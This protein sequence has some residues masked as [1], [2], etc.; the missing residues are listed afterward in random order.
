MAQQMDET[1]DRVPSPGSDDQPAPISVVVVEDSPHDAR[2]LIRALEKTG[3]AVTWEQT[4]DAKGLRAL[5]RAR[6]WDMVFSDHNMPE[7]SGQEALEIVRA[8][9]PHLPFVLVSGAIGEACAVALIKAGASDYLSKEH[10]SLAGHVVA[11]VLNEAA[12]RRA[13][14]QAEE[15]YRAMVESSPDGILL[16]DEEGLIERAN[17]QIGALLGMDDPA[18]LVGM[19][20]L[21]L[22]APE[23]Q[24]RAEELLRAVIQ[25][26]I[27]RHEAFTITRADQAQVHVEVRGVRVQAAQDERPALLVTVRD[28]TAHR[29][30][31]ATFRHAQKMEAI[32]R[33]AGGVAHDFNNIVNV[34][35]AFADFLREDLPA[36]D[37][38][39]GHVSEILAASERASNL[40]RQLLTFSRRSA[41]QP[42]VLDVTRTLTNMQAMLH[43]ILG[44]DVRVTI[45]LAERVWPVHIDEGHLEQVITNLAVNARDALPTG[46]EFRLEVLNRSLR[47]G[48]A[49]L[50]AGLEPGDHVLIRASDSGAGIP[51]E[52]HESI[53]DPFFTTKGSGRGTGLGLS[54]VYAILQQAK[55]RIQV[56]SP[57]GSGAVFSIWLPRSVASPQVEVASA[58]PPPGG[59]VFTGRRVLLVE[60]EV[61][62]RRAT[63]RTLERLGFEVLEASDGR[64][65]L[66]LMRRRGG[67]VDLVL[68]DVVMP[69]MSGREL[70][71]HLTTEGL[72]ERFVYMSGYPHDVIA[73]H[74]VLDADVILVQKPFTSTSLTEKLSLAFNAR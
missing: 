60:D 38:R 42:R 35:L 5:L 57:P 15:L 44:E 47:P 33:L 65:A 21:T 28:V 23:D 72:A 54:T 26:H 55:G 46:G 29:Q 51:A 66:A 63:C 49:E 27:D 20:A 58:R 59:T 32:G 39:Q 11:R 69:N 62:L 8:H 64:E 71:E 43:R 24:A 22:I 40:T 52:I 18:H 6:A 53:F 16:I 19:D 36:E 12:S 34:I 14:S 3:Y 7:F 45:Q 9:D 30:L 10:L 37:D 56:S 67:D 17:R 50:A 61:S 31:E 4:A 74:G 41:A 13:R 48:D 2:F 25:E 1:P 70:V 73:H 68:T